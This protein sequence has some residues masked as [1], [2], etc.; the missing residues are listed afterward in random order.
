MMYKILISWE[1]GNLLFSCTVDRSVLNFIAFGN[2]GFPF[3]DLLYIST[4]VMK[5]QMVV[6]L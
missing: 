4:E 6:L 5:C 1:G 3:S 2:C